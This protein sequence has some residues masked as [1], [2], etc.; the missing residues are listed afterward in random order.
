MNHCKNRAVEYTE[1]LFKLC[2]GGDIE[3]VDRL[4]QEQ[5][6]A[7]LDNQRGQLEA[8]TL[9]EAEILHLEKDIIP[10]KQEIV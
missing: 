10:G 3:M 6:I 2:S 4:V 7:A 5:E 1:R 9:T 8:S